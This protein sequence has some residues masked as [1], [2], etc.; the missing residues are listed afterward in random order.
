MAKKRYQL[1]TSDMVIGAGIAIIGFVAMLV[2]LDLLVVRWN[3]E[4]P[5]M[6]THL[7]P[8]LLIGAGILLLFEEQEHRATHNQRYLRSGERQ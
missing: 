1:W 6:V 7:W 2:H 8:L 5:P 3:V 4:L